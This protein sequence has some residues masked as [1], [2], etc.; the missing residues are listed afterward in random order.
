[1]IMED[2][3][4]TEKYNEDALR[5]SEYFK[6]K[7]QTISKV[8]VRSLDDFSIWYTP[9]VAAVSKKIASDPD[10]SFEL[11]GRWNSIAILTDGT[12]VLGLGNIGPEAAMPVMEGKALIF[13]YLGGVNAIPVPIRVKSREEF[14]SVAKA[15]EPSFGGINL[16]DIESPKCFF[17]LETLQKEMNIPVWHD[18]QL[19]TASITLAGVINAL[20]VVG[21]KI[22]QVKVV[23]NGA[24]AA[25]IAA[26]F[27]FKA[28]GFKMKNMILVDSKGILQP[29]RE[30]IDSLMINNPWKYQLA[31]ETNGERIK[32]DL[33]NAV[34]GA[35]LLISAAK[36][37][38]DTIDSK[39][40][41][42]MNKDAVVFVLANPIPE[43]WPEE[44]KENGAR[45]VA[46]G[47]SDFSN[48][49]NNSLV[50]PGVFRG[51]LDARAKGVNFDVMVAA[52]Y[53]IANFVEE[54]SEEKIVPTMEEWELYP[55]LASAVASKTVE[56]GLARKND[57][58]EGFYRRAREII[59]GNRNIYSKL[60]DLGLIK[61][62]PNGEHK[63]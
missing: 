4:R 20:R 44:A 23:F 12:R 26:A 1:M 36:S 28:A 49:I 42:K 18:D 31:I 59:E 38:P 29:E 27:L 8:P 48:Q 41:K 54:P 9:G 57:S 34:E 52:S 13:N 11:T 37:G 5:Y 47:R 21:K 46:T 40:V 60:M 6:G 22:D 33:S 24:G 56:L 45:I 2:Q 55:R 43:M 61:R 16:E 63:Y 58:K 25:N 35:D 3:E 51:V 10:L 50:F 17:L 53:E 62:M 39:V 7:I 19:G 15:L 14:V 32:G 30:D